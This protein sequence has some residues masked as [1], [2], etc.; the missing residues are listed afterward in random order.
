MLPAGK[1]QRRPTHTANSGLPAL[2][3]T[4][5]QDAKGFR[6]GWPV[7]R[8]S[9]TWPRHWHLDPVAHRRQTSRRLPR[10]QLYDDILQAATNPELAGDGLAE[11][12][13]EGAILPMYGM[14]SRSRLLFHQLRGTS[15]SQIDRDLDLAITE[16]A[17]GSERTKDKRIHV[18]IGFTT[19]YLYRN[20]HWEPSGSDPLSGRRWMQRCERCHFT[21]TTD[22][23]PDDELC[24]ECGCAKDDAP[25]AF[26]IYQFA[27]P[28]AFR[29]SMHPGHDA[30]EEGDP[31]AM[32]TASV[33]ESEP[34]PCRHVPTTNSA[35]AY[36][37]AGRV[38]RINDRRGELFT[39][40]HGTTSRRGQ[41]LESQ[42][43]DARY[44]DVDDIAF[45][46]SSPPESLALASPK[47]TDVLRIRPASV[48]AGIS[49]DPLTS[50]GAV[51]AAYYSAAFILRSLAA[52]MLDTDPDEFE[53]SNVRQVELATGQ[54]AGEIVLSD[55][56]T[57]GS[58]YVAWVHDNWPDI[59]A[60]ATSTGEPANTFIGALTSASHRQRCDAAGYDCLRQYR[61]MAFHGLLDW[62]L[63]LSLLRA[64]SNDEFACGLDGDFA[65][66]HLDGWQEF[67][68]ERRDTFC[69]TFPCTPQDF[70][71]LPGFIVGGKQVLVV[72]PLWDTGSPQGILAKARATM[73][74]SSVRHL[75]TFNLLRRESWSYQ[76]LST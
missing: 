62:R 27:V 54:K 31:L 35:I 41:E 44:Q 48:I 14:P 68:R 19:P 46:P 16:F 76:L 26:R 12:L 24:P 33:A 56:L 21:R 36:S 60:R 37:S 73:S 43:I 23:K 9:P 45:S 2:G 51:K 20:G 65:A 59:L 71:P 55:H 53:V 50:F 1:A 69:G 32:G 49:L 34:Q 58:G 4:T 5:S 17:P 22:D 25:T 7:R 13:A 10:G 72:H 57:N 47:T 67:A 64:I 18:P 6:P 28:L 39:G 15:P 38:Y 75:D 66:P 42:W 30:K 61:N 63:G 3:T 40:Q 8:P 70:G 52:E 11:Q 74:I 29:T